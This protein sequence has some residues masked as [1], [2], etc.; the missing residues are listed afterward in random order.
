MTSEQELSLV[1]MYSMGVSYKV[2]SGQL[3]VP[4]A[5]LA[6]CIRR[7]HKIL[8]DQVQQKFRLLNET[9]TRKFATQ[10]DVS[11][12]AGQAI[13]MA[14]YEKFQNKKKSTNKEFTIRFSELDFPK[15]CPLLGMEL[16]YLTTSFRADNYPTYDRIDNMK[17]YVKGNVHVISWKANRLKSNASLEELQILV[18]NLEKIMGNA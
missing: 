18:R 8:Q 7:K 13:F 12:T 4:I 17:G 6:S 14:Q 3:G 15:T 2:I 11:E 1:K 16:D 10:L 5:T 9:Y